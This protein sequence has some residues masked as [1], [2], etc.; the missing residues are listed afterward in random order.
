MEKQS[1]LNAKSALE[2]TLAQQEQLI[3]N[4]LNANTQMLEAISLSSQQTIFM[5]SCRQ[6]LPNRNRENRI[7][8]QKLETQC[9]H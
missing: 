7:Y 8:L 9:P 6:K 2:Q 5:K 4:L 3:Q 1:I